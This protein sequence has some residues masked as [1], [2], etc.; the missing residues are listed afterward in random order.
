MIFIKEQE[1]F[2]SKLV[3]V[4]IPVYNEEGN[5]YLLKERLY[6]VLEETKNDFELVFVNDGS[7]DKTLEILE[8]M[9][10]KDDKIK[11][12]NFSRNFGHQ[13]AV[14]AG[15]DNC[16]GDCAV[17]IDADLQDPPE[18]IIEMLAKWN[19]GYEVV[20][21]QREKRK[22]ESI[23]KIAT[24]AIF[25]RIL[26][27]LTNVDIPVDTGDFRLIDRKVVDSLKNMPEK[28]RF[29]R[30]MV[31]WVGFKQI[32]VKFIREE[33]HSGETKYPLKKMLKFALT[34]ITSFSFVPLQLATYL[35]F[36][37]SGASFIVALW[38]FYLKFFTNNT[39]Q[40]WASTT[41][42]VLFLGG[43]QLITLGIIGEYIGRISEEIKN[44]P[45]YIVK[46]KINF[47]KDKE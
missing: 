15:L 18:L 5:I 45:V 8:N 3:S 1:D 32:G 16:N 24:A 43:I 4:V 38:V 11:I 31:S 2:M 41:I 6:K 34:G 36:F 12:I 29:I 21:A 39:I 22:G 26:K 40:G 37:V 23:F 28:N 42:I 46:D 9:A 17:I 25:Y 44:R 7:R 14:T 27:K 33:R 19:E 30:G 10:N 35:G 20:F 13:I 47:K